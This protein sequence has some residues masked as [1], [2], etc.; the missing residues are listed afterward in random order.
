MGRKPNP[1]QEYTLV[2]RRT[3]VVS[4]RQEMWAAV[5]VAAKSERDAQKQVGKLAE[6][7]DGLDDEGRP[8]PP[9]LDWVPVG[10]PDEQVELREI[11]FL[12]QD[13]PEDVAG[14][15]CI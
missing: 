14:D 13:R 2:V 4:I 9:R 12:E 15:W 7:D 6:E 1:T 5:T 11:H 8:A 3:R 10:E